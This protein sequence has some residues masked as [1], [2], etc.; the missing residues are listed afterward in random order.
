V[1]INNLPNLQDDLL[2]TFHKFGHDAKLIL[3]P[4][5]SLSKVVTLQHLWIQGFVS[6]LRKVLSHFPEFDLSWKNKLACFLNED[7]TRTFIGLVVSEA[8]SKKLLQIAGKID[9]VLNEYKLERFYDPPLF[10]V[11]LFWM[12]GD[13]KETVTIFFL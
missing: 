7:K 8:S 6:N 9:V 4:H 1:S 5:I 12:L 13:Q 10:H 3:Q 2:K 11:S